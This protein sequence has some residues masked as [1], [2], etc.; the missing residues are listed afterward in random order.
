[1][2]QGRFVAEGDGC[3]K[4]APKHQDSFALPIG[5]RIDGETA[6]SSFRA[7][8]PAFVE[9]IMD[10]WSRQA[11]RLG[12]ADS[13][14]AVLPD[15]QVLESFPARTHTVLLRSLTIMHG[16]AGAL[17]AGQ[18]LTSSILLCIKIVS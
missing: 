9:L 2:R 15:G 4:R 16:L 1:M 18:V 3:I 8:N 12:L 11:Y 14:M 17:T 6:H 13:E 5:R 7:N 10:R